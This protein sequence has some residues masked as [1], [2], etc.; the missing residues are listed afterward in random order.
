[1]D[2]ERTIQEI[3]QLQEM[4]EAPDTR[5]LS[6]SD[7]QAANQRVRFF[8]TK[9]KP[10]QS[11]VPAVKRQFQVPAQMRPEEESATGMT[12]VETGAME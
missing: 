10:R 1:M 2:V 4:F 11:L 9:T 7:L 12:P 3:E 8:P 5:P 6:A